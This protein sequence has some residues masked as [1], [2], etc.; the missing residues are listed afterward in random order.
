LSNFFGFEGSASTIVDVRKIA[1][2]SVYIQRSP[3]FRVNVYED[4]FVTASIQLSA[5][6]ED[7]TAFNIRWTITKVSNIYVD[8]PSVS[9]LDLLLPSGSLEVG[10]WYIAIISIISS[11]HCRQYH[12]ALLVL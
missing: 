1:I 8:P 10:S 12:R 2:P 4:N 7:V 6:Q 11:S 9:T 5:C 3:E